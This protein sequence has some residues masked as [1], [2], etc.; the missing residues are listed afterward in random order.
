MLIT[1]NLQQI[2]KPSQDASVAGMYLEK[3]EYNFP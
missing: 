3:T 1:I 2:K